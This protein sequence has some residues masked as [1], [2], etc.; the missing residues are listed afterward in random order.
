MA[1]IAC[2]ADALQTLFTTTA[3]RLALET[4][5]VQRRRVLTGSRVAQTLV[6]SHL[7]CPEATLSQW[8][9]ACAATGAGS[10]SRQALA[11]HCTAA[12]AQ[13]LRTLLE[14][15]MAL[16]WAGDPVALPLLQRFSA[17][18]VVDSTTISLPAALAEPW[19]GCGGSTP[20]AGAAAV[21][22]QVRLDLVRGGLDGLELQ[23]G[24]QHDQTGQAQQAA[25]PV[26]G[27][28]LADL[29]YF[30]VPVLA[31][32]VAAGGHFLCR[33][34]RQTLLTDARGRRAT[35]AQ[36]LTRTRHGRVEAAV[37]LGAREHLP[38]RLLA[39]RLPDPVAAQRLARLQAA[40]QREGEQLSAAQRTLTH[41]VVLVTS[42]PAALLRFHEALT[43]YRWRWQ[44]E[45]LFKLWK[46]D[47]NQLTTWRTADPWR[48][49]CTVYAKLLACLVQHWLLVATCWVYPDKSLV[50]AAQTIRSRALLLLDALEAGAAAIRR[51]ITR[52]T[53][54]IATGCRIERRRRR[55]P[56]YHRLLLLTESALS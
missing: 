30:S 51:V 44:I 56:A 13:F 6:F 19:P 15:A 4:R 46:S 1:S 28:R 50:Q 5:A 21:K 33:P 29:G 16:L 43:L 45:L 8:Q 10:V 3:D 2:L 48:A 26:G 53:A 22:L 34:K 11:Q 39:Q 36:Y 49:I 9:Q 35:V 54:L 20:T 24:R 32:I 42:A 47:G 14:A 52:L 12:M 41:W 25:V 55:P 18:L 37:Q 38:C 17:V 40:A 7:A 31:Q 23:P 27:L